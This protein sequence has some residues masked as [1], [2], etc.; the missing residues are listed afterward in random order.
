MSSLDN[1]WCEND[2]FLPDGF[3]SD[4][5]G[6][7]IA[8]RAYNRRSHVNTTRRYGEVAISPRERYAISVNAET[9]AAAIVDIKLPCE[10]RTTV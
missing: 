3:L 1:R 2:C 6:E 7:L 8:G 9:R 5:F 4:N 10:N